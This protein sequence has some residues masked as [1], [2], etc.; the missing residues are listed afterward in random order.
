MLV[1]EA[2]DTLTIKT[3]NRKFDIYNF[4]EDNL[5]PNNN[6]I[7]ASHSAALLRCIKV[8]CNFIYGKGMTVDNGFWKMPVNIYGL[9]TDQL[10]RTLQKD[11]AIH[12]GFAVKLIY[13]ALLEVIGII[14][15]PFEKLRL[16]Y[17]DDF[18]RIVKIKYCKD[19]SA[20]RIE[21]KDIIEYDVYNSSKDVISRQ[22]E[23]AGGLETWDGQIYYYGNNG[24]V[25]YPHCYY[26]S[27]YEDVLSD[28]QIK[29]GKNAS[30]HTNFMGSHMIELPY[31]FE[32]LVDTGVTDPAE[33]K[34]KAQ[35]MRDAYMEVIKTFQ[36]CE[37]AGNIMLLENPVRD[38]DGKLVNINLK[39]FDL[40]NFDGIYQYTENSIKD[41][42]RGVYSIP[43]ILLD[44]VATGFSTEIMAAFYNYYNI[45]TS[46]DR[47]I[48][49][50]VFMTLFG[51]FKMPYQ[52]SDFSI[53]QLNYLQNDATNI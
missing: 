27:A 31:T 32:S 39:K 11:Y 24:E 52:V 37:K 35:T 53:E 51:N 41:N 19:W 22:I 10:L 8:Y 46:S 9:R 29:K 42:I 34:K 25:G 47:Q 40:Q 15:I 3:E 2:T 21:K 17:A 50:E 1:Y 12:K 6:N 45:T 13:N 44:P 14:P 16:A 28:I 36:S 26:H 4:G 7:L 5:Y 49:E 33:R 43:T 23:A 18:G 38:N 48:F 30:V 20:T